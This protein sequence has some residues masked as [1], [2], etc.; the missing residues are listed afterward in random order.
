MV[1]G[2]DPK[3]HSA[4]AI[5]TIGQLMCAYLVSYAME[6]NADERRPIHLIADECQYFVSPTINQIMGETRK[7]GLYATLATQRT[8]QVGREVLDAI[9]GN[10]GC[11]MIGRN[12]KS[13]A[14]LMGKEQPLTADEIRGLPSLTFYQIETD[15]T[16]VKTKIDVIGHK[17]A[18]KQKE[19]NA[20]LRTQKKLYYRPIE[21]GV[22]S[23]SVTQPEVQSTA[24]VRKPAFKSK[25]PLPPTTHLEKK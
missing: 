8:E 7:F 25:H 23:G 3:L 14:D 19:W 21:E 24:R 17:F 20:V 1:F 11:Y 6:R 22:T 16:P 10:V 9:L 12:K 18:M 15:R 2:F 13:T 4:E 5:T